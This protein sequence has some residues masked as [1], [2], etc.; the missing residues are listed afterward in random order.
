MTNKMPIMS[1]MIKHVSG[2]DGFIIEGDTVTLESRMFLVKGKIEG[3][4]ITSVEIWLK[5][6]SIS[7]EAGVPSTGLT[8]V[9]VT[10]DTIEEINEIY[11]EQVGITLN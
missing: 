4:Q 9:L 11:R 2:D 7:E 5:N 1:G 8:E 6:P 10:E 3:L